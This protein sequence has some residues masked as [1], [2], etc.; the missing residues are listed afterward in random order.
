MK[1]LG[2][3]EIQETIGGALCTVHGLCV[4]TCKFYPSDAHAKHII[5]T[6]ATMSVAE[7]M[8]KSNLKRHK[9]AM[10]SYNHSL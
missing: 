8:Y 7:K 1:V 6:G 5:G 10:P 2:K 4:G 9:E 3:K